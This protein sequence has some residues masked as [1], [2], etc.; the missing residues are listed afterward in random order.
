MGKGRF[1]FYFCHDCYP[2]EQVIMNSSSCTNSALGT[3]MRDSVWEAV[4]GADGA[5]WVW[6]LRGWWDV[7]LSNASVG[8]RCASRVALLNKMKTKVAKKIMT[9][10]GWMFSLFS[11]TE[12]WWSR[13]RL[14][15]CRDVRGFKILLWHK[16]TL[17]AQLL[18]G[19]EKHTPAPTKT[20]CLRFLSELHIAKHLQ[21][22][23]HVFGRLPLCRWWESEVPPVYTALCSSGS[24]WLQHT[25][26]IDN[27]Y[28]TF[29]SSGLL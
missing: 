19:G 10:L 21:L 27:T 18:S 11:F 13:G 3:D 1:C 20:T 16:Q 7:K 28:C 15:V 4:V 29:W 26:H 14:C 9:Q 5:R 8:G 23:F 24:S 22:W 12:K 17:T 6:G 25:T 2:E